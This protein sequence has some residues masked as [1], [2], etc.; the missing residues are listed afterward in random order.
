MQNNREEYKKY[1]ELKD[2]VRSKRAVR[3]ESFKS[4]TKEVE[5]VLHAFKPKEETILITWKELSQM[6]LNEN[7]EVNDKINF[8]KFYEDKNT[9]KFKC[10]MKSGAEFSKHKHN[11][12]EVLEIIQ[13]SLIETERDNTIYKK[14]SFV[15]YKAFE[16][17]KPFTIE[18]TVLKIIHTK[19]ETD[20]KNT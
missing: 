6:K 12:K 11:Y 18:D 15:E 4:L 14:G 13:G 1:K 19:D 5:D 9:Q 8:H 10:Y 2:D 20:N 7:Y 17:H 3:I 16:V